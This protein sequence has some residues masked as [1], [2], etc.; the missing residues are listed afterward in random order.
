MNINPSNIL[1]EEYFPHD[2]VEQKGFKALSDGEII[3]IQQ[4]FIKKLAAKLPKLL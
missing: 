2:K 1:P 3:K 4:F